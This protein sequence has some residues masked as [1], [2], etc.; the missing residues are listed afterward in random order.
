MENN[1][2]ITE[3]DYP[4]TKLWMF[5]APIIIVLMNIVA[6]FFGYYF[7][8]LVLALPVM[9]IANPLI[10]NR[11]HYSL[12]EKFLIVR[13]GVI[14]KKQRNLPYGVI[15]NVFLKQDLFDRIFGLATLRI[16]N[17]SQAGGARDIRMRQAQEGVGASGNKINIPGL[18]KQSAEE[19]KN[20]ILKKIKENPIEDSQSGL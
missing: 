13:Q 5:K 20:L 17:A 1:M 18:K 8:Y 10:R 4:I 2:V 9:L 16:E 11:F 14:S 7:P 15:Q 19:L 3:R 6:L 12:E